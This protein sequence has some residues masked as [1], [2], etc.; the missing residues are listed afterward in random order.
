MGSTPSVPPVTDPNVTAANQQSLN[1]GALE[2]GQAASLISQ[3]NPYG[4]YQYVQTGTGPNG[5][6]IYSSIDQLTPEEQAVFTANQGARQTAASNAATMLTNSTPQYTSP[7]D[8]STN[9]GSITQSVMANEVGYLNPYF[10]TQKSQLDTQL[11][12]QGLKPGD[13]GY[14]VAMNNLN[15]SQ[16]QTVTGFEAQI[17][18]QA[19]AQA[20]QSYLTPLQTAGME[21]ALGTPGSVKQEMTNT[22]TFNMQP[23]NLVGA[24]ASAQDAEMKAYQAQLAQSQAMMS[25][26]FGIPTAIAGGLARNSA[27]GS[28]FGGGSAAAGGAA[29]G[30]TAAAA[31]AGG[32]DA[33]LMGGAMLA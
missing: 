7:P 24:T 21:M 29:A 30:G 10:N 13:P 3:Y 8:L 26:I 2:G 15:Q 16:G 9:A 22:P 31:D 28:L 32:L 4:S 27:L 12:T 25:G 18:P 17:E 14:D 11:R 19:Y 23:A 20:L 5:V 1:I 6:P 33:A